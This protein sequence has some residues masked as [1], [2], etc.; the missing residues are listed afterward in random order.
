MPKPI[1]P[2]ISLPVWSCHQAA[3]RLVYTSGERLTLCERRRGLHR[4]QNSPLRSVDGDAF[5]SISAVKPARV[6]QLCELY[7]TLEIQMRRRIGFH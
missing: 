2:Q 7:C 5:E 3:L 4:L 1:P 6:E